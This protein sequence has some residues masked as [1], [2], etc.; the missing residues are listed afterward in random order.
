MDLHASGG[1]RCGAGQAI[2]PGFSERAAWLCKLAGDPYRALAEALASAT[3]PVAAL[4]AAGLR[5]ARRNG[6]GLQSDEGEELLGRWPS[7]GRPHELCSE[8]T[9]RLGDSFCGWVGGAGLVTEC[10]QTSG[11]RDPG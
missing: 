10:R 6:E 7:R 3:E 1:K 11:A 5:S 4:A 9:L 8:H 2:L